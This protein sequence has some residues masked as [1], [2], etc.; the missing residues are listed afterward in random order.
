MI[1]F[2]CLQNSR[3]KECKKWKENRG[4]ISEVADKKE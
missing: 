1:H 2:F 4:W 3:Q